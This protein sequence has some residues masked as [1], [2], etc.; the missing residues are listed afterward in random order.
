[1]LGPVGGDGDTEMNVL[2]PLPSLFN[3]TVSSGLV[4]GPW[5]LPGLPG[6]SYSRIPFP[7]GARERL[8]I[9]IKRSLRN[10]PIQSTDPEVRHPKFKS[11]LAP[12]LLDSC[13]P[14]SFLKPVFPSV[15]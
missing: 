14:I 5:G 12:F 10:P 2:E 11:S 7:Y 4:T 15:K 1:M 8:N 9:I 3:G 13:G 6:S